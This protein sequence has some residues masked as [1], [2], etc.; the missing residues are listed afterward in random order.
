MVLLL[1]DESLR[2]QVFFEE[3]DCDF[4][5]NVCISFMEVCPPEEKVFINDETNLF[6]TPDQAEQLAKVLL[7]AASQ[8][9]SA[10]QEKCD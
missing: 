9:R 10:R 2:V 3:P 1:L 5:D 4:E 6:L 8:S 7:Q